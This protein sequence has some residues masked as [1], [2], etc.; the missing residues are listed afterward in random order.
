[1]AAGRRKALITVVV[2]FAL[3]LGA[4]VGVLLFLPGADPPSVSS[5]QPVPPAPVPPVRSAGEQQPVKT[6]EPSPATPEVAAEAADSLET[7]AVDAAQRAREQLLALK[8]EAE[9]QSIG[10]WGGEEY[11]QI[12]T[13]LAGVDRLLT[14]GAAQDAAAGYQNLLTE[15]QVLLD[16]KERRYREALADGH[17]SLQGEEPE[18][19]RDHFSRALI[20]EPSSPEAQQG[21]EQADN[22]AVVLSTFRRALVLEEQGQL[23]EAAAELEPIITAG[24]SYAPAQEARKRIGDK[25]SQARFEAEMNTFFSALKGGDFSAAARSLQILEVLNIRQQEV[26]QASAL[27]A[28]QQKRF[29]ISGL[30]EQADNFRS[31]EQW[32]QALETYNK[33]LRLDPDLLFATEGRRE[34][35]RRAE[36]DTSLSDA[37]ER[38]HR[39]QDDSQRAAAASLLNF[40]QQIEPQ[41]PKLQSQ[42]EALETLLDQFRTPVPVILESDNQTQV[43]IYHVGRMPPFFTRE[44]HLKPGTYTVLGSRDGFRDVRRE[45]T[46]APDNSEHRFDIRCEEAI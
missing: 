17:R 33:I 43:T 15:L 11:Q 10:S 34:S 35:A 36:L 30:K 45:I 24:S 44:I 38:S 40:A 19:A 3:L 27:L 31:G 23:E 7:E 20:I 32:Q 39:L 14:T 13:Q 12:I 4:A 25:L 1:M 41:G 21:I 42:I 29:Q 37:V 46:V 26:E 6:D 5:P 18:A 2:L 28:E 8:I 16:S 9:A 22:L